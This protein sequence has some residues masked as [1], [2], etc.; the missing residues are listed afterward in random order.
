MEIIIKLLKMWYDGKNHNDP[1]VQ[2]ITDVNWQLQPAR[3]RPQIEYITSDFSGDEGDRF[4]I[5][6]ETEN[7]LYFDDVYGRS[8][9]VFKSEEGIDF[10]YIRKGKWV[11]KRRK[12]YERNRRYY[13]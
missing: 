8:V 5:Y 11:E 3:N 10:K 1:D 2:Q 6:L 12:H 7:E 13:S 9:Y 4:T